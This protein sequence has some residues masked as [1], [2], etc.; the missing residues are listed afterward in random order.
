MQLV[1]KPSHY[2]I[3]KGAKQV[4]ERYGIEEKERQKVLQTYFKNGLDGGIDTI[5]SKEKKSSLFCNIF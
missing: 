5:P 1:S 3:H 4:D 2:K